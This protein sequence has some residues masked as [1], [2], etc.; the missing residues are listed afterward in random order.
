MQKLSKHTLIRVINMPPCFALF[1]DSSF[2]SSFVR[3]F[4]I[5]LFVLSSVCYFFPYPIPLPFSFSSDKELLVCPA[6]L[7]GIRAASLKLYVYLTPT[8]P[9]VSCL[10]EGVESSRASHIF[11]PHIGSN[12][13]D[14]KLLFRNICHERKHIVR[15]F[16]HL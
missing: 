10:P 2:V 14:S 11:C 7:S 9:E 5:V 3:S 1:S 16:C 13:E 15:C 4:V 8:K 6:R 12:T